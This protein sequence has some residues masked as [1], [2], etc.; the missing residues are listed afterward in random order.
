MGSLQTKLTK[1]SEGELKTR[2][3]ETGFKQIAALLMTEVMISGPS[4]SFWIDE[5]EFYLYDG[6]YCRDRYTHCH[7]RQLGFGTWYFHR[8]R[9]FDS[10][11]RFSRNGL[12]LTFGSKEN[13]RYGGIL[14]RA[15]RDAA[16]WKQIKGINRTVKALIDGLD[17][18]A[19]ERLAFGQDGFV[20][21]PGQPLHLT[22]T[23][24]KRPGKVVESPRK[25][26][27][28]GRDPDFFNKK[29]NYTYQIG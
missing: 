3:L 1:L 19:V 8:Y 17:A 26:L 16:S 14:L 6:G 7:E 13:R 24:L 29:W 12:D 4:G 22:G 15:V 18:R 9:T 5:L 23:S 2:D 28:P 21:D 11:M 20:F 25:G 27:N 10:F